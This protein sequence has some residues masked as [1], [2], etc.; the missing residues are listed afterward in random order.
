MK[1]CPEIVPLL[2]PLLDGAL[3]EDDRAWVED[4]LCG[5]PSCR[6]RKA[7][8]AAQAEAIREAAR[9]ADPGALDFNGLSRRGPGPRAQRARPRFRAARPSWGAS[10]G[11]HR[12][13]VRR[14]GRALL[15]APAPPWRSSLFSAERRRWS[16]ADS[17][18]RTGSRSHFDPALAAARA[19]SAATVVARGEREKDRQGGAGGESNA[20]AAANAPRCAHHSSRPRTGARSEARTRSLRARARTRSEKPLKSSRP[21]SAQASALADGSAWAAI[22]ASRSRQ[23]GHADRWSS[24]QA[25]S[26]SGSAPSS[27]GRERHDLGAA[28]HSSSSS[29]LP[30]RAASSPSTRAAALHLQRA[31]KSSAHHRAFADAETFDSSSLAQPFP[32]RAAAGGAVVLGT[33]RQR[34]SILP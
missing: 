7:L 32:A 29:R 22:S 14:R 1:R 27:S 19:A 26:S 11:G 24:T 5:C 8:I 21:G 10:C 31:W 6:D 18:R 3:P 34:S 4:H 33:A 16:A 30:T 12:R 28:L 20:A 2:G 13:R 15:S 25:R 17:C 9:R 23:D